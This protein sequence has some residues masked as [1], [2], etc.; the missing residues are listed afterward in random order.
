[1]NRL[2]IA[3]LVALVVTVATSATVIIVQQ[4]TLAAVR[5]EVTAHSAVV[6]EIAGRYRF[7]ENGKDR[8]F[9]TLFPDRSLV[10]ASGKL[11][12][13]ERANRWFYQDGELVLVWGKTHHF[14]TRGTGAG[15][16]VHNEDGKLIQITKEP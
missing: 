4:R 7:V 15:T 12:W 3:L 5:A 10:G 1:M 2:S 8:G 9:I 16:F 6:T 11:G 13:G 14:F